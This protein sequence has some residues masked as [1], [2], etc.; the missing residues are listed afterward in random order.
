MLNHR[1]IEAKADVNGEQVESQS[2]HNVYIQ[3][4]EPIMIHPPSNLVSYF[5]QFRTWTSVPFVS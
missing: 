5:K 3:E 2:D 4:K 1:V